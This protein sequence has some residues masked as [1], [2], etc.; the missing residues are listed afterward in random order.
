MG[1]HFYTEREIA[2]IFDTVGII[3]YKTD[4]VESLQMLSE[5]G[6]SRGDLNR[7]WEILENIMYQESL[8]PAMGQT[9]YVEDWKDIEL[10]TPLQFALAMQELCDKLDC[11]E[12]A[13]FR[14]DYGSDIDEIMTIFCEQFGCE[15]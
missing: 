4:N 12:D 7:I 14:C 6:Y 10:D 9:G 3:L 1:Y 11:L 8:F 2:D 13:D 15:L 5:A